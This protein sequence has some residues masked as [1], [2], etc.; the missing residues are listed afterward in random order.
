MIGG[1][2]ARA[3]ARRAAIRAGWVERAL[4]VAEN[5]SAVA[6]GQKLVFKQVPAQ[7]RR[8]R[9]RARA[10]PRL[11]LDESVFVRLPSA[12]DPDHAALE[13]NVRPVERS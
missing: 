3:H 13:I 9:D 2:F 7:D 11:R 8:D 6:P 1:R 5:E 4:A 12:L 10:R